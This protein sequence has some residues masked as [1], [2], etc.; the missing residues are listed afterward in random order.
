M[1]HMTYRLLTRD[2]LPG[3]ADVIVEAYRDVNQHFGF[4]E[5]PDADQLIS[6]LQKQLDDKAYLYGCY[7]NGQQIGCFIL[8]EQDE[9]VFEVSKLCILPAWRDQGYGNEAL[10]AALETI[11]VMG[12]TSAV[13]AVIYENDVVRSWLAR[14]GFAEGFVGMIAG[15]TFSIC[16]MQKSLSSGQCGGCDGCGE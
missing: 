13:A 1:E 11:Q 12:G 7:L 15:M 6:Q 8:S 10:D 5:N 4:P 9:E 16:L 14:R 2:D 3:C